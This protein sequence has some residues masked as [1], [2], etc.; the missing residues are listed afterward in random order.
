M[1]HLLDNIIWNSL[2]GPQQGFSVGT[3]RARRY[4]R[5][6]SPIVGFA[7]PDHP[8]FPD[9]LPYCEPDEHFYVERWAGTAPE[10][11]QIDV[12]SRM[13]KMIWEGPTPETDEAPDA[14]ALGVEHAVQAMA[15]AQLTQPGPFGLRTIELGEYYGYFEGS[16]L[17]AMAG[18]RMHA[19]T[20]REISGV[21]THPDFQGRGHAR[22][23]MRKLIRIQMQRGQTPF[24]HVMSANTGAHA[25]YVKMGFVDYREVVVRVISRR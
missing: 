8:H 22:R 14:I 15:L 12:E 10:G 5:G 9:L 25:L 13:R 24:L 21:C 16:R 19:G 6:F 17:I 3:S 4:T 11:W 1:K 2:S 23:L 20:L 7:D 18:E